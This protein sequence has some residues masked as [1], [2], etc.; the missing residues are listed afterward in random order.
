MDGRG[1]GHT[2]LDLRFGDYPTMAGLPRSKAL[3]DLAQVES[4]GTW[5][6][7]LEFF[8]EY[9][10]ERPDVEYKACLFHDLQQSYCPAFTQEALRTGRKRKFKPNDDVL[11]PIMETVV[12]M[13]TGGRGGVLFIGIGERDS[14][15]QIREALARCKTP[16][17]AGGCRELLDRL[18]REPDILGKPLWQ[19]S[20]LLLCGLEGEFQFL[21]SMGSSLVSWDP[22]W[23]HLTHLLESVFKEETLYTAWSAPGSDCGKSGAK[24]AYKTKSQRILKPADGKVPL[25]KYPIVKLLQAPG[26]PPGTPIA[27]I[28]VHPTPEPVMYLRKGKPKKGQKARLESGF[29]YRTQGDGGETRFRQL[30]RADDWSGEEYGRLASWATSK[31]VATLTHQGKLKERAVGKLGGS[32]DA[33]FDAVTH[34]KIARVLT[35][36]FPRPS[37]ARQLL[38]RAQQYLANVCDGEPESIP[39][40]MIQES[41][42]PDL[43]HDSWLTLLDHLHL[44]C[45]QG[46]AAILETAASRAEDDPAIAQ[47]LE[48]R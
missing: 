43:L 12:A 9:S 13:A 7:W 37:E 21:R 38:D 44:W 14:E 45:P 17:E 39:L 4:V 27:Y 28:V 18:D 32:F 47:L 40:S 11:F 34:D 8:A 29:F 3:E 2:A 33:A 26:Q 31:H 22:W 19:G 30:D 24:W 25:K 41:D 48:I 15:D 20:D 1:G 6:A 5:S 10:V 36:A 35:Q 42:T 16:H 23:R 46:I